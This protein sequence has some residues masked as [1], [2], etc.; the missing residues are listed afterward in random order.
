MSV[1]TVCAMGACADTVLCLAPK[2]NSETVLKYARL[3]ITLC[4]IC[5][6]LSPLSGC[7]NENLLSDQSTLVKSYEGHYS[8]NENFQTE[9]NLSDIIIE[10][11]KNELEKQIASHIYSEFGISEVQT[12]IQLREEITDGKSSLY[13]T[14]VSIICEN[15][16]TPEK[17]QQ[18]S[19]LVRRLTGCQNIHTTSNRD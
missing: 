15:K 9:K 5:T 19:E 6:M 2:E 14:E 10:N 7:N 1:F 4:V 11:T 17:T 12:R 3:V 16:L 18:M 13:I 8:Q